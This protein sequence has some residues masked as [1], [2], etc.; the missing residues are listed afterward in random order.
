MTKKK[1]VN[2]P[3]IELKKLIELC[4][5]TET[6]FWK[7]TGMINLLSDLEI[8]KGSSWDDYLDGSFDDCIDGVGFTLEITKSNGSIRLKKLLDESSSDTDD[9][10]EINNE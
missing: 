7:P 8:P 6:I 1:V 9:L 2:L 3:H 5:N 4:A 10:T